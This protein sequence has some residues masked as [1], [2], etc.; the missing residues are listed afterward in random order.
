[1]D[2]ASSEKIDSPQNGL[3]GY[4]SRFPYKLDSFH[5]RTI[6]LSIW[7]L[8]LTLTS[9]VRNRRSLRG[10]SIMNQWHTKQE[11]PMSSFIKSLPSETL[12]VEPFQHTS[13]RSSSRW[14]ETST[15]SS[16]AP[17]A[18]TLPH[19]KPSP[20]HHADTSTVLR[21]SR[22]S[23]HNTNQSVPC[24]VAHYPQVKTFVPH[25]PQN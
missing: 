5:P 16:V 12:R 9:T 3:S 4:V 14:H 11:S 23:K 19:L 20:S 15:R 25:L 8:L 2:T 10:Q 6:F 24:A 13:L 22:L 17:S 18:L 7:L 1:M 21:V